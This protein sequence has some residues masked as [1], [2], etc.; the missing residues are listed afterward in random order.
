MSIEKIIKAIAV[1]AE[2][3]N[4]QLSAAA[5]GVMGD[6]LAAYPLP[7]VLHALTRCRKEL[8]GRLTLADVLSRLDECDG[9]PG[10][11]EAWAM[12]PKTEA[13]SVVW[14]DEMSQ[15]W[16]VA[17]DL[18]ESD[19]IGARMAFRATYERLV[20]QNR[21][22][23]KPA[24][25]TPSLGHDVAGRAE[26]LRIALEA[27]RIG[28]SHA[29]ALLP[30]PTDPGPIARALIEGKPLLLEKPIDRASA[31]RNISKIRAMFPGK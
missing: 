31:L 13:E 18:F 27:G 6:D 5:M 10:A 21:E 29:A 24:H 22:A 7:A 25:W 19:E 4:T 26:S 23:H 3:T 1:T 20:K 11:D 17:A 30:A 16:G 28:A 9:R 12:I 14:S 8:R 15:A 2:L